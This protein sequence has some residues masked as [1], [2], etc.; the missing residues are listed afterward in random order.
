MCVWCVCACVCVCVCVC[1]CGCVC[2]CVCIVYVHTLSAKLL[3]LYHY[4]HTCILVEG[5][6]TYKNCAYISHVVQVSDTAQV[7]RQVSLLGS[8]A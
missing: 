5:N 4:R 2:M 3:N 8:I 7:T 6:Y 1:G